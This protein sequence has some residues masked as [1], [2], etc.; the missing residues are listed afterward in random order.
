M[1]PDLGG[2]GV[3]LGMA[4]RVDLQKVIHLSAKSQYFHLFGHCTTHQVFEGTSH[5]VPRMAVFA[6]TRLGHR[7]AWTPLN[8]SSAP[9]LASRGT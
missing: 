1:L 5:Q 3:A 8:S 4:K 9:L 6:S 7:V 2:Y